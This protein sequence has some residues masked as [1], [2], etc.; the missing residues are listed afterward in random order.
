MVEQKLFDTYYAITQEA[1]EVARKAPIQEQD[2]A[3]EVFD[4]VERYLS[5]AQYF[6]KNNDR[7]RGFAAINYAHGWL[8]CAA[9][10]KIFLVDDNRLFTEDGS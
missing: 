4:M 8:D 10:M 7:T 3:E 5:D 1:L 2:K 9:R 6:A